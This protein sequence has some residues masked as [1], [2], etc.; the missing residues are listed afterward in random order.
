M[1][2]FQMPSTSTGAP[3]SVDYQQIFE[4]NQNL[5]RQVLKLSEENIELKFETEQARKDVPR[6]K[7]LNML[8]DN[9]RCFLVWL[10]TFNQNFITIACLFEEFCRSINSCLRSTSG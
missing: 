7:V 4:K 3:T 1:Y 8:N 10:K 6:L 5:Q 2:I 9:L